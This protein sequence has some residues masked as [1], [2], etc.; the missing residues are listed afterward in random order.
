MSCNTKIYLYFG[1]QDKLVEK[2]GD[3]MHFNNRPMLDNT[4]TQSKL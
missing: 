1:K 3:V 2:T 4:V